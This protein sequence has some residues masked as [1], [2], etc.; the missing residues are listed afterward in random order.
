ME[1]TLRKD[2]DEV[3][4][5]NVALKA[6]VG[7]LEE[8]ISAMKKDEQEKSE[9]YSKR[10]NLVISGVPFRQE[11]D[12]KIL[13]IKIAEKCS[14]V[15]EKW[16]ILAAHRLQARK[17]G[18]VPIIVKFH[19]KKSKEELMSRAKKN[20][21][22]AELFGGKREDKLYFNEHLTV[23]KTLLFKQARDLKEEKYGFKF[24]WVRNGN[25]MARRNEGDR[26]EMVKNVQDLSNI[27]NRFNGVNSMDTS[28]GNTGHVE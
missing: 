25:V 19:T 26:F 23:S 4:I 16:D 6:R 14:M 7:V 15:F 5:E 17:N 8:R 11:E 12:V 18:D 24:V 3:K 20:N 22:T 27:K 9:Q 2:I 21:L 28:N 10:N 13:V 1:D